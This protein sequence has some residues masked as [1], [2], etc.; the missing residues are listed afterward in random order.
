VIPLYNTPIPYLKKII[1][2]VVE[3]TYDNWQLCLADGSTTTEVGNFIKNR[4][5]REQRI[6]YRKLE[7]NGGISANTNEA[8]RS[9]NGDFILLA[10]H[11]DI[12]VPQALYEIVKVLNE[13]PDTEIVYTDEDKIS[14]DGKM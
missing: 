4:Y 5:G 6:V 12:I 11:D 10:D 1:D 3:Q 14:M 7:K 13:H 9:A 2:S 8:L